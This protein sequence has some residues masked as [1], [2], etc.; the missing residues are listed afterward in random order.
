M[1]RNWIVINQ[2]IQQLTSMMT[3]F[4]YDWGTGIVTA[5]ALPLLVTIGLIIRRFMKSVVKYLGDGAIFTISRIVFRRL[6]ASLTLGR[7]A[8]LVL[9]G[10]SNV[11][12]IPSSTSDVSLRLDDVFVPLSLEKALDQRLYDHTNLL[13]VGSR[14]RITGDPGSG[15]S[16]IARRLFRDQCRLATSR[17]PSLF[18]ILVELKTITIPQT[19]K[20]GDL[21][22]W[23][24]N[25][26][27]KFVL[28]YDV[29]DME[30]CFTS[31]VGSNGLL[32]IL[33]GLDEVST[34][35]YVRVRDSV[36]LLSEILH[37]HS[38]NNQI[39]MTLRSQFHQQ[40]RDDYSSSFPSVLTLRRF[41]STDI[42]RFLS[43]WPFATQKA[44][45]ILRIYSDLSDKPALREMCTN[46]LILSMYVARDQE[47]VALR[48]TAAT[49]TSFYVSVTEE[50]V[51]R[52]RITQTRNVENQDVLRAQRYKVLGAIAFNHLVLGRDSANYISW[53]EAIKIVAAETKKGPAKAEELLREISKDTGLI[54]EE[55]RGEILRF[56]H[57][58]FCEFLSAH[59]ARE[60]RTDGWRDIVKSFSD[61]QSTPNLSTRLVEVIPFAIAL[62]PKSRQPEAFSELND[63]NNFYMLSLCYMETKFYESGWSR[64]RSR[65]EAYLLASANTATDGDGSIDW[66]RHIHI[67][68]ALVNDADRALAVLAEE[69]YYR[70]DVAVFFTRIASTSL[71]RISSLAMAY[72]AQDANSAYR[73]AT[74]CGIDVPEEIPEMITQYADQPM[75]LDMLLQR[76]SREGQ[77]APRLISL[78]VEAALSSEAVAAALY[79]RQPLGLQSPA[80]LGLWGRSKLIEN[81]LL[82]ECLDFVRNCNSKQEEVSLLSLFQGIPV[83]Y[84]GHIDRCKFLMAK[85][86][87]RLVA[88][89]YVTVTAVFQ[90]EIFNLDKHFIG[91][92]DFFYD[93]V[94][95]QAL[96]LFILV[97]TALLCLSSLAQS[98]YIIP[99]YYACLNIP[100][101]I[102]KAENLEGIRF[103]LS[104]I[105]G[106]S[107]PWFLYGYNS[108][109]RVPILLQPFLGMARINKVDGFIAFRNHARAAAE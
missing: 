62:L 34:A 76:A 81:T 91:R 60:Y 23:L 9:A 98:R 85:Y 101:A 77:K 11:L 31:Y 25:Y 107:R 57:L 64:F 93:I 100:G 40:I 56:I 65:F 8:N 13:E 103:L 46:P 10:T 5:V 79:A 35:N 27:K 20:Y 105:N 71:L 108:E 33:D 38:E 78:I 43:N 45:N 41:S 52:R 42:Y 67:Y 61:C 84:S 14:I 12:H 58:T 53:S 49:R 7:Y 2:V 24:F 83:P 16:T 18:P 74:D 90:L 96:F 26:I 22:T 69:E 73:V 30:K 82:A 75:F 19:I 94:K 66:F 55:R 4:H 44:E 6:S 51:I 3:A 59:Y 92:V 102:N 95:F 15:K 1:W 88:V 47:A 54:T 72:A 21:G 99:R 97:I 63:A 36:N 87:G 17:K 106:A 70:Y 80:S 50:L 86:L 89:A 29:F 104:L 48:L 28:G 32:L 68:L 37:K 39:V 109:R